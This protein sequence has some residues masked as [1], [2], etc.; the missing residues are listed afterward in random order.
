MDVVYTGNAYNTSDIFRSRSIIETVNWLGITCKARRWTVS[1]KL[2]WSSSHTWLECHYCGKR[3]SYRDEMQLANKCYIK[4]TPNNKDHNK[5]KIPNSKQMPNNTYATWN[6]R[7]TNWNS[8]VQ[9]NKWLSKVILQY[10]SSL[11]MH[12]LKRNVKIKIKYPFS[13]QYRNADEN[14]SVQN[15]CLSSSV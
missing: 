1:M 5:Y 2:S 6:T 4:Y 13:C 3:D 15:S 12:L 10:P 7:R 9:R 14:V 8:R 11:W